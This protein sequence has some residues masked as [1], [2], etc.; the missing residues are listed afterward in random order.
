MALQFTATSSQRIDCGVASWNTSQN[1]TICGWMYPNYPTGGNGWLTLISKDNNSGTIWQSW[2]GRSNTEHV[3]Y[4]ANGGVIFTEG[5]L[6]MPRNTWNHIAAAYDST[7]G[8]QLYLNGV[9]DGASVTTGYQDST[10][11]ILRIAADVYSSP[12]VTDFM[13]GKLDDIRV[14]QRTLSLA[15]I[16][17]IYACQGNDNINQTLLNRY[18]FRAEGEGVVAS[19]AGSI[20]DIASYLNNGTPINGP[21]FTGSFL[22]YKRK[23]ISKL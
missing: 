3:H 21:Y 19:G 6:A 14:Y 22:K 17:T 4:E 9:A 23:I 5:T 8:I 11:G 1:H 10:V 18:I 15:E 7:K 20:R 13:D 16:Q 12:P 2:F